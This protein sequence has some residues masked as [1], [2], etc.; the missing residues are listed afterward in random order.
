MIYDEKKQREYGFG[1][2]DARVTIRRVTETQSASGFPAQG[3]ADVFTTFAKVMEAVIN[4]QSNEKDEGSKILANYAINV[5]VRKDSQTSGI[6][7]KDRIKY[8][9]QEYDIEN[10]AEIFG[11]GRFLQIRATLKK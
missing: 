5:F 10:I 2:M 7:A 3:W 4:N 8:N 9:T 6:T 1:N 11:R